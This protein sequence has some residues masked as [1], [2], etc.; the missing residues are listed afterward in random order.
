MKVTH[1]SRQQMR[2]LPVPTMANV[3][4]HPAGMC[5]RSASAALIAPLT[6]CVHVIRIITERQFAIHVFVYS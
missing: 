1:C 5:Q 3:T 2:Y 4:S 6:L